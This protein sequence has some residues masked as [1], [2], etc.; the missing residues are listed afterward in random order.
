MPPHVVY[1]YRTTKDRG[2]WFASI[3]C[4][5]ENGMVAYYSSRSLHP[6]R[7][8]AYKAA[9]HMASVQAKANGVSFCAYDKVHQENLR[10][11]ANTF[12]FNPGG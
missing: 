4:R 11:V 12:W 7:S 1:T 3:V 2:G 9:R 6:T 8:R 10:A 5:V